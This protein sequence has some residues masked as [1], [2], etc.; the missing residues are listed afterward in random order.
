MIGYFSDMDLA[1]LGLGAFGKN[2]KISKTSTLYNCSN[3]YIGD[4]VRIDNFCVIAPSSL[5]KF[6]IGNYVHISAYNLMNGMADIELEDF[7]TMAPYVR[8]FSSS[9][10]YSGQYMTNA[11]V[12][13]NL[14]GTISS[15]V[16]VK[17]H[18][19]IGVGSTILQGVILAEGTAVA[20]H[21]FVNKSTDP[22][23][24]VG[25]VPANKIKNRSSNLLDLEKNILF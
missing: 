17:K 9:D 13:R 22:F 14:I 5:A 7:V 6:V 24:I 18:S 21:S 16:S 2:V 20:G 19:I 15:K 4:N 12:P 23:T 3:I 1:Q 8:I 10:D 11:V 25:G